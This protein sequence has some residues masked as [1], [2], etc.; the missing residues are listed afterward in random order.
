M[1]LVSPW[2]HLSWPWG[3]EP[4]AGA[5]QCRRNLEGTGDKVGVTS[6]SPV[7][8]TGTGTGAEQCRMNLK[9]AGDGVGVT[10]G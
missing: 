4:G 7:L 10:L 6:M 5:E 2:C 8:P 1:G 9:G 3:Q